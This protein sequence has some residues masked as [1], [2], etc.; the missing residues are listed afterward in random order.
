MAGWIVQLYNLSVLRVHITQV[1]LT[2]VHIYN[3]TAVKQ[4]TAAGAVSISQTSKATTENSK[5]AVSMHG[6]HSYYDI[7]VAMVDCVIVIVYTMHDWGPL[8]LVIEIRQ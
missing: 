5:R 6:T 8:E 4:I 2:S 1:H 3:I 7:G